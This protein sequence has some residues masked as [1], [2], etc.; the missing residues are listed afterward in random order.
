MGRAD[1]RTAKRVVVKVGTALLTGAGGGLDVAVI[2]SIA[3]QI[4]GLMQRGVEV[5]IVTSAAISAGVGRLGLKARPKL[6]PELQ[7]AAAVGQS[8]LI[9]CYDR[10]F[11]KYGHHVAQ[12][13][14]THDD[15]HDRVRHLNARN[16]ITTLLA[17]RVI[18]VINENDTVSADEIK[19]GDNDRLS[20]LVA[21]LVKADLLLILSDIE[22]LMTADPKKSGGARLIGEVTEI[23]KEIA[24]YADGPGS[25][26]G[27][28][29]MR[30]KLDAARI[31]TGA[32]EIAVIADG[33]ERE[34]IGRVFDG[35]EVGTL[36]LPSKAKM[37]GRKRWIAYFTR[38]RG[39]IHV[40]DGAAAA[41][42]AKGKSLLSSGLTDVRG[43]FGP[44]DCV[45]IMAGEGREVGRGLVNYASE[46][47]KKIVGKK[48][49][50]I[51]G[52][53]GHKYYDEVVHRD[54]LVIFS[55]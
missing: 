4:A 34:I 51:E 7:A 54:N 36:F 20:A 47:L 33:R 14:L 48:T 3:R 31:V 55:K 25:S 39:E 41:L 37:R 35:E 45:R 38:P 27:T 16:T 24:S 12:I 43:E 18:P 17:S 11:E 29:G 15:L 52:I 1:I 9:A 6:L 28:G 40:D 10:C 42:S 19:F 30:S 26:R 32:G 23:T 21:N 5:V 46:E 2:D 8:V 50:E 44:G 49:G 53:L 22:G 13:L